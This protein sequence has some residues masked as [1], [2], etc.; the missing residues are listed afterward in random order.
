MRTPLLAFVLP[1]LGLWL[2]VRI[3]VWL[4]R[5]LQPD[6]DTRD[7]LLVVQG[8]TLTLLGLII[9]FSFSMAIG[10]YD[11][12][13]VFEEAEANAIRTEFLRA[14]LLPAPDTVRIQDLLKKYLDQ[15]IA[16]YETKNWDQLGQINHNV[17]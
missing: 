17:T 14:E 7:D 3:G 8:A 9:G 16:F 1:L 12:R 5:K 4:R 10:R 13:K 6:K 15:R 2:S 11:Q